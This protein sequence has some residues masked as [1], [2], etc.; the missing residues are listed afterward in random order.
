MAVTAIDD[1]SSIAES[2]TVSGASCEIPN[3]LTR[4]A[5]RNDDVR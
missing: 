5:V 3:D 4:H 1:R 2:A